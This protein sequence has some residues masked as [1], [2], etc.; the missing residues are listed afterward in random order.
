MTF[1][2]KNCHKVTARGS[3]PYCYGCKMIISRLK[4]NLA[5]GLYEEKC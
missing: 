5:E 3:Y 1:E 4:E 2:C